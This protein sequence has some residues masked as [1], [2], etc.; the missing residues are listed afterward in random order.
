MVQEMQERLSVEELQAEL[1]PTLKRAL[2]EAGVGE[3]SVLFPSALADGTTKL[4]VR[5]QSGAPAAVV[6]C[7]SPVA[8]DMV[9]RGMDRARLAREA[10]GPELGRVICTPLAEGEVRGLS[11]TVLPYLR[12]LTDSRLGWRWQRFQL[13]PALFRWLRLATSS[14]VSEPSSEEVEDRFQ[15]AL[16]HL[17]AL[18]TMPPE[19]Q[20]A[21]RHGLRRLDEGRWSPRFV[22]M[23]GDLWKGNVLIDDRDHADRPRRPWVERFMII[24]W[25]GAQIDGYGM[26]DLVRIAESLDLS[27]RGLRR[28]VQ[29][30][31]D[32]LDCEV[33]DAISHLAAALGFVGQN[34]EHFPMDLYVWMAKTCVDRLRA[35]I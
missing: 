12:P 21:A 18:D 20:D 8:P 23:H 26:Y 4:M 11:Y 25:P 15:A 10:L 14:T 29:A 1:S 32:A 7:A 3:I 31:C 34:L 2:G 16:S 24:D 27:R 30:H 5:D 33:A 19:V 13:R 9:A 28:E 6:L 22:L 35:A 17:E